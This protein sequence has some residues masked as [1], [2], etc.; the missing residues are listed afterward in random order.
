MLRASV[1]ASSTKNMYASNSSRFVLTVC[2]KTTIFRNTQAGLVTT[3][4]LCGL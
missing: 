1:I 3:G 2:Q 4:V